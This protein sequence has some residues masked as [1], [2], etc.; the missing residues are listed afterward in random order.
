MGSIEMLIQGFDLAVREEDWELVKKGDQAAIERIR[1]EINGIELYFHNLTV[2]SSTKLSD[3][4]ITVTLQTLVELGVVTSVTVHT[5][6]EVDG[7]RG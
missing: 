2:E 4:M 5:Q 6:D 3:Q 1:Q 7:I